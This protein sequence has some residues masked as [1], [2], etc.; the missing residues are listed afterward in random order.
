[1][2]V[3]AAHLKHDFTERPAL[4]AEAEAAQDVLW[5]LS[6]F[7]DTWLHQWYLVLSRMWAKKGKQVLVT[8]QTVFLQKDALKSQFLF[9]RGHLYLEISYLRIT[10]FF[11]ILVSACVC[12]RAHLEDEG[13]D[14]SNLSINHRPQPTTR[15]QEWVQGKLCP[16]TP[17]RCHVLALCLWMLSCSS[18]E[19]VVYPESVIQV[20]LDHLSIRCMMVFPF[21]PH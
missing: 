17:R 12:H 20:C 5:S 3:I 6:P 9:L 18:C 2:T 21:Q 16:P 13:R 15:H 1:M 11:F 7:S 19:T 10:F 14:W 8:V 4:T